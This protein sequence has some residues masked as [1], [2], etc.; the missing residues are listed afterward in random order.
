MAKPE[1]QW[2]KRYIPTGLDGDK[3]CLSKGH[4]S[5][6]NVRVCVPKGP[7]TETVLTLALEY[8]L[9]KYI[10]AKSILFGYMDP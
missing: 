4:F 8:S 2:C 7:C 10:G 5:E 1:N 3:A 9:Y 6:Y